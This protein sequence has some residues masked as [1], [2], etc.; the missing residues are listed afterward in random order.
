[1]TKELIDPILKAFQKTGVTDTF[2]QK[3]I[4]ANMMKECG[5]IPKEENLNYCRTANTRI[6]S[7]FGRR[8]SGLSEDE[9]SRVKCNI[10]EF[11][12]LIYGSGNN[13]GRGMGNTQPGDGWKFRG[14]GYIQLTGRSNYKFY[15]DLCGVDLID[16]PDILVRDR[17]TSAIISIRFVLQGLRG[18]TTFTSQTEADRAVTQV[19]GGNGLNLNTGYGAELLKKVNEFSLKIST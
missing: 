16:D 7:I 10:M 19:I 12:E 1:M 14:R 17:E 8:V 13:I 11:A 4:L 3:A 2:L 15:G 18:R 5:L 6:R 9:L